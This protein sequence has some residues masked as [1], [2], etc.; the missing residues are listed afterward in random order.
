MTLEETTKTSIKRHATKDIPRECCGLLVEEDGGLATLECQNVSETPTQ[1]FSIKP[2]DYVKASRR[3]K[4]KAV[5]HSHNSN[6]D[7]FSLND[8]AHSRSHEIPFVLYSTGKDCFSVFDP[9]KNKTF[10]YDKAFKLEESDCYTVVKE[11][12]KDLGIELADVKGCRL[13]SAWHKKN[14]SLI[15]DLFNL[16]KLNPHLPITELPP[17]SEVK[18]HDVLVFEFVKG[19]GPHHV[20]VYLGDGTIM[21]HPRNKHVCIETLKESLRKTIYKI[22]R[23]E[24]FS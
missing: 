14:P 24:Q 22:Y 21:H 4:I 17:T 11:Y 20:G 8:M 1:H 6:N 15:Q 16:N 9:R 5:Y 7:K 3:G 23:H 2:S 13:D 19:A 12:Y 18:Q 10:L